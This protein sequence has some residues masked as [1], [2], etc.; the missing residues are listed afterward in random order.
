LYEGVKNR[1]PQVFDVP[2]RARGA[3]IEADHNMPV[4]QQ[5][6]AKVTAQ[7]TCPAGDQYYLGHLDFHGFGQAL[8]FSYI[9]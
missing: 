1:Q 2:L 7:E 9:R 4:P 6:F 5:S 8:T 3:V